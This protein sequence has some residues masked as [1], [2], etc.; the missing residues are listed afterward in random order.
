MTDT[1]ELK[2]LCPFCNAPYTAEMLTELEGSTGCV[3]CGEGGTVY[4]EAVIEIKCQKCN[5]IVYRK[6]V[7]RESYSD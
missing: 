2:V 1:T 3:S 5:K 4:I 7:S 6:E